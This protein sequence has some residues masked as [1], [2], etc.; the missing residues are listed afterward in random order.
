MGSFMAHYCRDFILGLEKLQ[1]ACVK[2]HLPSRR[3]K[4]IDIVRL[5]DDCELPLQI[6]QC[7]H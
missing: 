3:N 2:H 4:G 1:Q 6:L 7:M 5:V